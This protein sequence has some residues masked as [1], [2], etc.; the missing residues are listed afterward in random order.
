MKMIGHYRQY[1]ILQMVCTV[2]F[3]TVSVP[4][5]ANEQDCLSWLGSI[6]FD[7]APKRSLWVDGNNPK[8]S[9][10]NPGT[11]ERPWRTLQRGVRD[12]EPGDA[13]LIKQGTYRESIVLTKSGTPEARILISAAPGEEVIVSGGVLVTGWREYETLKAPRLRIK[14]S[15]PINPTDWRGE[16]PSSKPGENT[17]PPAVFVHYGRKVEPPAEPYRGIFSRLQLSFDG[18]ILPTVFSKQDLQQGTWFFDY[19]RHNVHLWPLGGKSARRSTV[20]LMEVEPSGGTEEVVI[21]KAPYTGALV[22]PENV[23]WSG[24]D[25]WD[26]WVERGQTFLEM[27]FAN[28]QKLVRMFE[29]KDLQPGTYYLDTARKEIYCCLPKGQPMANTVVEAG[30]KQWLLRSAPGAHLHDVTIRGVHFSP[31]YSPAERC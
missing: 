6:D 15:T 27:V 4:S 30:D 13:L 21:W 5:S 16:P 18:Q 26:K 12:L 3:L 24:A 14:A 28:D 7:K 1:S 11:L 22:L 8:A 17:R 29:L 31:D 9:D 23:T 2:I 19:P 10:E 20:E 25:S